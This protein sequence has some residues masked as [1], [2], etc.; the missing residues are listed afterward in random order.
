MW[1]DQL[2]TQMLGKANSQDTE[3][4]LKK[5]LGIAG[6]PPEIIDA[7]GVEGIAVTGSDLYL[8]DGS[9]VTLLVLGKQV[10][11]M[12]QWADAALQRAGAAGREEGEALGIKSTRPLPTDAA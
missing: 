1:G 6:I 2:F 5:Q 8:A 10:V 12:R 4:R 9:D 7:M 11:Q 3:R